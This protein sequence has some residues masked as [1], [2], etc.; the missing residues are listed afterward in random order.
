MDLNQALKLFSSAYNSSFNRSLNCTPDFAHD[1]VNT[2][3]VL[4]F[5][6][7]KRD[8]I[9]SKYSVQFSRENNQFFEVGAIVRI[10][11]P[12]TGFMKSEE[13]LF[14]EDLFQIERVINSSPIKGY[15]VRN[16]KSNTPVSATFLPSQLLL[17]QP[18]T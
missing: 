5:I 4:E 9:E 16:I 18:A 1:P 14:S 8:E 11:Y 2:P 6:M 12:K 15:K 10:R 3:T 7:R 17:V 13:Y